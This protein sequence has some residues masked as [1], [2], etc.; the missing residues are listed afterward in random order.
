MKRHGVMDC[1]IQTVARLER[2]SGFPIKTTL[3]G[4]DYFGWIGY[5]GIWF[6]K[7]VTLSNGD[8][9]YKMD[10]GPGSGEGESYNVLISGG[11]LKKH[12][13][14]EMTLGEVKNIPMDNWD[15]NE[16]MS[17]H[18]KWDGSNFI[19]Y[20]YMD[21]SGGNYFWKKLSP[22]VTYDISSL[23]FDMLNFWSQSLGGNIQ[24]KLNC[25]VTEG[26]F[27]P[28][29]HSAAPQTI[30]VLLYSMLRA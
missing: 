11:K 22:E 3:G 30:Q 24:I 20:E 15:M 27:R 29:R 9:V 19:K 10:F 4:K 17:Y 25:T 8:Q 7:D 13:R 16:Q 26:T 12:V 5:Y 28:R 14:K 1:M 2:D 6:P 21:N 18:V 23:N